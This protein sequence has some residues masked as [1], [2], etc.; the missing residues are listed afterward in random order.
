MSLIDTNVVLPVK[1]FELAEKNECE[2]F[3]NTDTFFND[4]TNKYSYLQDYVLSKKQVIEW[5]KLIQDKCK[6]VNMKI[7]HMYGPND[8]PNKF[9]PQI[10]N[11]LKDNKKEI[12]LSPGEQRRDF[13]YMDDVVSS[14][15]TVLDRNSLISAK[16][17]E[18]EIG[19]SRS[20]SIREF[21]ELAKKISGST[22]E[23]RF[24]ALDYRAGEIME[25]KA[26]IS[27]LSLLGWKPGV[28][29]EKGLE[30]ILFPE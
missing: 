20:V 9:I 13:I 30:K 21:V 2:I 7:F 23:L 3:I 24:G 8:A 22:S 12:D 15:K 5:L 18:F 19:T 25:S 11:F 26:D 14:F 28:N 17:Q 1:L 6:L 10:I 4:P 16:F 27:K 29:L